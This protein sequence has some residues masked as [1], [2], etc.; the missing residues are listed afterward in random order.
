MTSKDYRTQNKFIRVGVG[1]HAPNPN[2]LGVWVWSNEFGFEFGFGY[3]IK[4][5]GIIKFLAYAYLSLR[6]FLAVLASRI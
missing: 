6:D 3:G 1:R 4:T 2:R 5:N